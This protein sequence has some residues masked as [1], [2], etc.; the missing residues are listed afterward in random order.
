MTGQRTWVCTLDGDAVAV[1]QIV[2]YKAVTGTATGRAVI[3]AFASDGR[4]PV[5]LGPFVS[6]PQA[7]DFAIEHG[8]RPHLTK[9]SVFRFLREA[10]FNFPEQISAYHVLQ[11]MRL[12]SS[13]KRAEAFVCVGPWSEV[14]WEPIA[15]Y[16]RALGGVLIG[17]SSPAIP[18]G[19]KGDVTVSG[20]GATW[21]VDNGAISNCLL[22][23]SDAADE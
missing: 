8:L 11:S 18:D 16:F 15:R 23:T 2:R 17:S 6:A 7:L 12:M 1:D 3:E 20:S 5:R 22:Y 21:T 10:Y 14:V 4:S 9:Y 13:P 19:D